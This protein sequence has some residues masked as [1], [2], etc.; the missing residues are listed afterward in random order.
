[1]TKRDSK[2]T[3]IHGTAPSTDRARQP[4][5]SEDAHLE[6]YGQKKAVRIGQGNSTGTNREWGFDHGDP[7]ASVKTERHNQPKARG[8]RFS[9]GGFVGFVEEI[10]E[11]IRANSRSDASGN[12]ANGNHEL[13]GQSKASRIKP[14]QRF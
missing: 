5:R 14:S 9:G 10:P 1:M 7:S 4:K 6:K 13:Q 3:D 12:A 2:G 11:N 8:K